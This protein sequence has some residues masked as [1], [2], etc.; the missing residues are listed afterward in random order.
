MKEIKITKESQTL[1]S[2]N[3]FGLLR[4]QRSLAMTGGFTRLVKHFRSNPL[5]ALL[6]SRMP[7]FSLTKFHSYGAC[8][9]AL[10]ESASAKPMT[11]TLRRK[12]AFTLAEVLITLSILG[13]VAAITIPNV[14]SNYQKR[15]T[16]TKLQIVYAD[17]EKAATNMAIA[18]GC[19]NVSC[20][21][22]LEG[23]PDQK[24]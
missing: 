1:E 18:T 6:R 24:T 23:S 10:N 16:I 5:A 20:T 2:P 19:L 3:Y 13:V 22:I 9:A 8:F 11:L 4:S 12:C 7:R 21:N 14:I 15:M 17:L